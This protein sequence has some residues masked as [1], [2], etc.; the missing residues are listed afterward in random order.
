MVSPQ[1]TG[2]KEMKQ[3]WTD[4]YAWVEFWSVWE[5]AELSSWQWLPLPSSF[6]I[7]SN[8]LMHLFKF[9]SDGQH[10]EWS[11]LRT[12]VQINP[13][14]RE[15]IKE[16]RA[17]CQVPAAVVVLYSLADTPSLWSCFRQFKSTL[18]DN[19]CVPNILRRVEQTISCS[20]EW[21]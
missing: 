10:T 15:L 3:A 17:P 16:T 18:E 13:F 21:R 2:L 19:V 6:Y 12:G 8:L 14:Q 7:N 11:I 20:Q 9:S 4:K 5:S 1:A